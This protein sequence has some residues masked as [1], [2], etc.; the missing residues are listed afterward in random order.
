MTTAR[1]PRRHRLNRQPRSPAD[2][3]FVAVC[4]ASGAGS[5]LLG[6]AGPLTAPFFLAR[7]LR[8]AA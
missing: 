7:D 5:A 4:A 6:S 3:A 2:G 8:R 1:P